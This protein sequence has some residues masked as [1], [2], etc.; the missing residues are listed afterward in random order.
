V[1]FD[2]VGISRS[3][4]VFDASHEAGADSEGRESVDGLKRRVG[5]LKPASQQS[6]R[7]ACPQLE[8]LLQ[9]SII[10][11]S[12]S[13]WPNLLSAKLPIIA[14]SRSRDHNYGPCQSG[15]DG[16]SD[17]SSSRR[18]GI[19]GNCHGTSRCA[20]SQTSWRT[21]QRY[22]KKAFQDLASDRRRLLD[23][24][25]EEAHGL[26]ENRTSLRSLQGKLSRPPSSPTRTKIGSTS[27][28]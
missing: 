21:R 2:S 28:G 10:N 4:W 24:C 25:A 6:S 19:H 27:S 26:L 14:P 9:L 12:A 8:H 20:L 15:P 5:S 17:S 13:R 3:G 16:C 1:T 18:A 11:S 7:D 22:T 23:I